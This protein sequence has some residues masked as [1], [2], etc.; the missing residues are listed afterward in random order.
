M[1][2]LLDTHIAVW[3]AIDPNSLTAA[4]RTLMADAEGPLILSSVS[5]WELRLKWNSL[6]MSGERKGPVHP[7]AIVSFAAAMDWEL[8]TLTA[9]HAAAE[10]AEPILHKDPF[11]EL[12]LI[13]AQE[14]G[15]RLLTRDTKLAA[16]RLAIAA[17]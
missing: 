13:Q 2:L 11:D 8:L 6:Y 17:P 1:R 7:A 15:M 14:E 4:E 3:A 12:L 16:H 5:V 9:K 10:L